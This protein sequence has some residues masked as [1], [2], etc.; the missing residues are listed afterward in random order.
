[1]FKAE[2]ARRF[3]KREYVSSSS[4]TRDLLEREAHLTS[5]IGMRR[6]AGRGES[7][8][9]TCSCTG[10]GSGGGMGTGAGVGDEVVGDSVKG[11]VVRVMVAMRGTKRDEW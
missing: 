1:M 9:S 6:D 7:T 11:L 4:S 3:R 8:V 5:S 10:G 2:S